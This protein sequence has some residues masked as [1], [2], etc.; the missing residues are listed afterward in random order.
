MTRSRKNFITISSI[1]FICIQAVL[2]YLIIWAK[3]NTVAFQYISVC[4]CFTFALLYYRKEKDV[5]LTILAL[6]FTIIADLFLVIFGS[7]YKL[8][9]MIAF[10]VV[11]VLYFARLL[12]Q[13]KS[14][15]IFWINIISRIVCIAIALTI[16]AIILG[17]KTDL[18][19]IISIFYYTNIVLNMLLAFVQFKLSP[20][21]AVGLLLFVLCDTFIGLQVASNSYISIPTDSWLYH[22]IFP[23]FNIAWMFYLPSQTCIALSVVKK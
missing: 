10:S 6:L 9:G 8:Y 12:S 1:I 20:I 19:S 16:T 18:L 2:F 11:Q 3:G 22:I 14:Q 15:K 23:G 5:L 7:E 17:D 21:F 4:L 13:I